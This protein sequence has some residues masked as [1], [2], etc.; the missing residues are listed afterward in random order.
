MT[1]QFPMDPRLAFASARMF[2]NTASPGLEILREPIADAPQNLDLPSYI[3]LATNLIFACELFL[4][5][6]LV[7]Q[8]T[9]PPR[10]HNLYDLFRRLYDAKQSELNSAYEDKMRN[11]PEGVAKS[12]TVFLYNATGMLPPEHEP[13]S[14]EPTRLQNVLKD[15]GDSYNTWR[16]LF[17]SLT[18]TPEH[19]MITFHHVPL[20][21][22]C[23]TMDDSFRASL[24]NS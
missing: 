7:L 1:S 11:H 19:L 14:S 16:Y 12:H 17:Q 2:Q 13:E 4:K 18:R 9:S 8:G 20:H 24:A 5:V 3:C 23:Q 21:I 10:T 15:T 6:G 22:F